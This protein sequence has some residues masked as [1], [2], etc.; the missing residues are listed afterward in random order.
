MKKYT[1]IGSFL[2]HGSDREGGETQKAEE[3]GIL[4]IPPLI[5]R[6]SALLLAVGVLV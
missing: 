4:K 6:L 3:G 2:H 1:D 5:S